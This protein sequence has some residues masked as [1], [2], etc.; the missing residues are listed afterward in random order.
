M[1]VKHLSIRVKST[2]NP[3]KRV[4]AVELFLNQTEKDILSILP[5]KATNYNLSNEEY[6]TM[7]SL[8]MAEA[9]LLNQQTRGPLW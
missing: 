3:P 9:S 5:G 1:L 7:L 8:Q 2:W 6:L 4:P